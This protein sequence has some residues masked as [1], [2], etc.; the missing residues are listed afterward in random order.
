MKVNEIL[1]MMLQHVNRITQ[2]NNFNRYIKKYPLEKMFLLF[3]YHQFTGLDYGR[4]LVLQL[5]GLV[6]QSGIIPSQSELSKKLSYRLHLK[7]WE[8]MF[9][10]IVQEIKRIKNKRVR[11]ELKKILIIDSSHLTAT[12]TMKWARHR[13]G[14]NGLKLHMVSDSDTIPQ[15]FLLK[16]GNSS[17]KKS[18][19]WAIEEGYTYIFDRGYTDYTMFCWIEQQGAFFITRAWSNIHYQ[20]VKRRKVGYRQ[21]EK[22]VIAD[23][24]IEVIRSRKTGERAQFRMIVFEFIDSNG[25]HQTFTVLT[26]RRDLRSDDIAAFYRQRWNIEVFFYWI[27]SYLKVDHWMS[28]S[29]RGV[30]IQLYTALIAYLLVLYAKYSNALPVTIKRDYVYVYSGIIVSIIQQFTKPIHFN[31]MLQFS[32]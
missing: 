4:S 6:A 1:F 2:K 11:K 7:P 10:Y 28:R 22:G 23:A 3:L 12:P 31:K 14:K 16:Q 18:L 19:Q 30:M 24:E 13:K 17:D 26:N 21:K 27:K 25:Q 9:W 20:V 29:P 8:E 32:G 15:A 5:Q